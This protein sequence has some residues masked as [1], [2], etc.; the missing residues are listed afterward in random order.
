M[1]GII[2]SLSVSAGQNCHTITFQIQTVD[3]NT[4]SNG[5]STTNQLSGTA[6]SHPASEPATQ[7]RPQTGSEEG[8][9]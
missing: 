8:S 6:S 7:V 1:G 2:V 3:I 5:K 4:C 9:G